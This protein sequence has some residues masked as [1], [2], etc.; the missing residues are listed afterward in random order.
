MKRFFGRQHCLIVIFSLIGVI[1][2][3]ISA[4]I[5]LTELFSVKSRTVNVAKEA[6]IKPVWRFDGFNNLTDLIGEHSCNIEL[7]SFLSIF[8]PTRQE[9]SHYRRGL[10]N[11]KM[12]R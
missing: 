7:H 8:I 12:F 5:L 6:W 3:G 2:I 9:E 4:Y 1:G 10:F 11:G